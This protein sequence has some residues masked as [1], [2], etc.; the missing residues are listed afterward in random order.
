VAMGIDVKQ[1]DVSVNRHN[2]RSD[3]WKKLCEAAADEGYGANYEDIAHFLDEKYPRKGLNLKYT[4]VRSWFI[5]APGSPVKLKKPNPQRIQ[6]ALNCSN[7]ELEQLIAPVFDQNVGVNGDE[8]EHEKIVERPEINP[9]QGI[10]AEVTFK[11]LTTYINASEPSAWQAIRRK[12]SNTTMPVMFGL[13]TLSISGSTEFVPLG[14]TQSNVHANESKQING[15]IFPVYSVCPI[16]FE[17]SVTAPIRCNNIGNFELSANSTESWNTK[18]TV[19]FVPEG[20]VVRGHYQSWEGPNWSTLNEDKNGY[21]Q[22]NEG[23]NRLHADAYDLFHDVELTE[24]F[25]QTQEDEMNDKL[26]GLYVVQA[27]EDDLI[28]WNH[29]DHSHDDQLRIQRNN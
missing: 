8:K 15:K 10:N 23:V 7:E 18:T 27:G 26:Q 3:L 5:S 25:R 6:A 22:L 2:T 20:W 4:T 11:Q 12:L 1:T 28:L 24:Y 19:V 29:D 13:V 9:E 17:K 21:F 14:V 16:R